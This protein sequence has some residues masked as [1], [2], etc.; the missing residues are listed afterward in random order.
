M[1][2]RSPFVFNVDI[3]LMDDSALLKAENKHEPLA[4]YEKPAISPDQE[5]QRSVLQLIAHLRG[6]LAL[7]VLQ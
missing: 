4:P 6:L 2:G 7:V 1:L 5:P 3:P